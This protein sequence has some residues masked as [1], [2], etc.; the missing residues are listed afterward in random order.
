MSRFHL[1]NRSRQITDYSCGASALRAVLNHWG[2]DVDE[3]QLMELLRTNSEIGTNPENIASGARTLGFEAEVLENL[4]LDE[5]EQITADGLPVIALAQVWRSE[6]DLSRPLDDVWDNGHY[7]V[8][9]DV[10]KTHVSAEPFHLRA[11]R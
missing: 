1:L 11:A 3:A 2:Q 8:V 5:L 7:V 6:K 9:L 4:T 10:D